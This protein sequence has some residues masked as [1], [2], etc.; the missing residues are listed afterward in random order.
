[1]VKKA[2]GI[3]SLPKMSDGGMVAR[4]LMIPP[5]LVKVEGRREHTV[6]VHLGSPV[7]ATCIRGG[8]SYV[9]LVSLGDVEII[10]AGEIAQWEDE[11]TADVLSMRLE[12]ALVSAVSAHL[13]SNGRSC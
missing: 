1:M 11:Q 5:G 8:K 9:S 12:P 13:N 3:Y 2:M 7:R 4:R 6:S 10:P